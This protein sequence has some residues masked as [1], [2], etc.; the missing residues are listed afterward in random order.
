MRSQLSVELQHHQ[1][2]REKL[3]QEFP[4]ADDE[5]LRDTVEGLTRLPEIL[6]AIVRSHLY[7]VALVQ[8]LRQRI[9]DMQERY[10][11]LEE[12]SQRKRALVVTVMERADI[13]KL[14]EADFTASL[15]PTPPPLIIIDEA[16][17][18]QDYWKPQPAKLDRRG[19]LAMLAAGQAVP[20][21]SLGNG[22]ATLA[23]RT[24]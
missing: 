12:R 22:C 18:P 11:R 14:A 24:R 19:L 2:L 13:M 9:G 6:A 3:Q 16:K 4:E 21:A 5:T 20:G 10:A 23:V 7:D 1:F 8:A 17:I 15:R